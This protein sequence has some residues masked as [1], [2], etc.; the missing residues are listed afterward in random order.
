MLTVV[1]ILSYGVEFRDIASVLLSVL[2]RKKSNDKISKYMKTKSIICSKSQKELN[3]IYRHLLRVELAL[4]FLSKLRKGKPKTSRSNSS[5]LLDIDLVQREMLLL[6]KC[7]HHQLSLFPWNLH[8]HVMW[9]RKNAL[10]LTDEKLHAM[11]HCLNKIVWKEN[12][13][14]GMSSVIPG[15]HGLD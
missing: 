6:S 12:W 5:T 13:K 11:N 4:T 10:F 7:V 8:K 2:L 1:I 9:T 15:I 14:P 3:E